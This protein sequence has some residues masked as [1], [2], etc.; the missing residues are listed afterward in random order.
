MIRNVFGAALLVVLLPAGRRL[1]ATSPD[2]TPASLPATRP[3]TA[4]GEPAGKTSP[5]ATRPA[6]T[7]PADPK[8]PPAVKLPDDKPLQQQMLRDLGKAFKVHVS[9]HYFV[10]HDAGDDHAAL[11]AKWLERTHDAFYENFQKTAIKPALLKR[12]LVC[13]IFTKKDDFLRYGLK[14][15]HIRL[16]PGGGY[17]SAET[18][19]I[20]MLHEGAGEKPGTGVF[21]IP[22]EAA[23]QLA[24][25][26]GLQSRNVMYP[27]WLREG[28]ATNFEPTEEDKPFGPMIDG[29]SFRTRYLKWGMERGTLMPLE[30][31]L[32]MTDPPSGVVMDYNIL[33]CQG[34]A[35]FRY[36]LRNRPEQMKTYLVALAKLPPGVQ[37]GDKLVQVF[38]KAFGP[39]DQFRPVWEEHVKGL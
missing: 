32:G 18:N 1:A 14:A 11:C 37:K 8:T 13:L 29:A 17:Y 38:E 4:P 39:L 5:V 33:Y 6:T 26:T 24:N 15:D 2:A 36:L 31:I 25:N 28:L 35:L 22:H 12:R 9:D 7:L 30:Q 19:R 27:L 16:P 10:F 21:M 23:H 34:W 20:A 3:A